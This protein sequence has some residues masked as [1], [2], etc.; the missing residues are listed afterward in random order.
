MLNDKHDVFVHAVM[1]FLAWPHQLSSELI[2]FMLA[3]EKEPVTYLP[4]SCL[5]ADT[6]A[7]EP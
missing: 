3:Q 2:D 6:A 5:V 7:Y 4:L 1:Q